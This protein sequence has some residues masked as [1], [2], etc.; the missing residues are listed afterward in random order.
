MAAYGGQKGYQR[1]LLGTAPMLV[2]WSSLTLQPMEALVL[3]WC[4]FTGLWYMDSKVTMFGWGML[5]VSSCS[6]SMVSD[7]FPQ[8]PNG[9][10]SIGFTCQSLSA[11]GLFE[12]LIL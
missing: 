2:A 11:S 4:A 8:L 12:K 7:H 9:T 3:Q 1:L 10:P 6:V 5:F